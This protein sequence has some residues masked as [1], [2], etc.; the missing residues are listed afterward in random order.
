MKMKKRK[1]KEMGIYRVDRIKP[2]K[3]EESES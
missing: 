2:D 3:S 1:G